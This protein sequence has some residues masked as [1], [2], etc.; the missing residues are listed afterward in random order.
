MR[1]ARGRHIVLLNDDM[2]VITPGWLSAM[3]EFNQQ[4]EIGMVGA[5][6]L[7]PDER[8]QHVGVVMGVNSGAA[9]AFHEYPAGSI[10]YNAYTHLIRNYS[11]VTAAC[12]ATRMDVIEKAGG[13]DEAFATD[14]NDIDWCLRIVQK[15]Y[16]I[17]YTPYAELYHFEGLSNNRRVQDPKEIALFNSRWPEQ[18]RNDPYYNPNLTRVGVDF[19][20]DARILMQE[21]NR[22]RSRRAAGN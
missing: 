21:R 17:V 7:F 5:R 22:S 11:A 12:I 9:H 16:R 20:T 13:F 6:L 10:G 1:Q 4:E 19:S 15:G 3:I 8:I 14:F 2:E 18:I